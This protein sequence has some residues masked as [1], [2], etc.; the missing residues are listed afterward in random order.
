MSTQVLVV[1]DDDDLREA[2][3]DVL[4][5]AGYTVGTAANGREAMTAMREDPPLVVL[6]DLMMPMMNG[7]EVIA[8][9][10]DDPALA[11]IPVCVVSAMSGSAP[12]AAHVLSKPV[13]VPALLEAVG[14]YCPP[15]APGRRK[16]GVV[17]PADA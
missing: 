16:R 8:A 12:A 17:T 3:A 5:D 4:R 13:S 7:W 9:M 2:L 6:L 10:A 1:D 11:A 15:D 14:R